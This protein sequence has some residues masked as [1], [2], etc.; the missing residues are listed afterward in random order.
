MTKLVHVL[1][2]CN[3]PDNGDFAGKVENISIETPYWPADLERA[4]VGEVKFAQGDG[5]TIRIHRCTF[6]YRSMAYWAG[7]W[8]WNAYAFPRSEYR[9]LVRTLAKHGW[10]CTGGLTRWTDAYDKLAGAA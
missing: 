2:A 1:F 4:H 7:N 10:K 5:H 3:N 6:K 9:R 8:C